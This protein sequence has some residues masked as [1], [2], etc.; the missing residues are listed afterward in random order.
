MKPTD[1]ASLEVEAWQ[2]ALAEQ[3]QAERMQN[4]ARQRGLEAAERHE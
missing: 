2:Q 1:F 4:E 3:L